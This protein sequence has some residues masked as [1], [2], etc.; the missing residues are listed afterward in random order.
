M[1]ETIQNKTQLSASQ[2]VLLALK[3]AKIRIESYERAKSEP[4]AI[5]GMGCR[6]PGGSDTPEKYW[7]FLRSGQSGI[8]EIPKDRWDMNALYD[9]DPDAPGKIYIRHGGFLDR[10][11]QFDPSFFRISPR[12]AE[13]MDPQQ[14]L[15]LEVSY[16]ALYHAGIEPKKLSGSQTGVFVGIGQNDYSR[17]Q[18]NFGDLTRINAYDGTGNLFC[19][20]SG[21]LSYTLGLNG[22]NLTLD[23]ACSSSLVAIHLACQSLRSREC[24][25]ALAGGVH[26]VFSPEITVF[27][28]R[29]HVLS[30]DGLCRTFD[31]SAN[32]FGRGEGCGMIV[33]KRLSDA[34]AQNDNIL[35]LIRGSAINHDGAS[36][37]LTV[38]NELAQEALIRQA[39]TNAKVESSQIGY[40]EAHGTG[41]SLGDPIELGALASVFKEHSM[42]IG[43]V[44]TNFGHLEAA[45]GIAGLMKV[46][47]ALQ[48]HEIPPHLHF[49]EP[50]PR[51]DWD[52]YPFNVPT[53]NIAWESS[54]MAG[55]SSFGMSGTNAHIILEESPIADSLQRV[56]RIS[57][58]FQRE[59]YWVQMP[60]RP[61][62]VM[63]EENSHPLLGKKLRLPFSQ[64]IRFES[65]LSPESP[66]FMDDHRIFGQVISPAASHV[67]TILSAVKLAF[68]KESCVLEE[69]FFSRALV[70]SE[71]SPRKVQ[72]ILTPQNSETFAFNLV[73]CGEH[74][75]DSSESSWISHVSGKLRLSDPSPAPHTYNNAN[76]SGFLHS[77][78]GSSFYANLHQAGYR[79][80]TA[81]Q[82]G[83]EFWQGETEALCRI[84]KPILPDSA[85]DY[86]LYPGLLDTCFQ[87][88]SSFWGVK[89]SELTG[90]SDLYVPFSISELKFYKRPDPNK[91]L[92]CKSLS[93]T[94]KQN[95]GHLCLFDET[96]NIFA[97]VSGFEFRKANRQ[98]LFQSDDSEQEPLITL[99]SC[100]YQRNWIPK[101]LTSEYPKEPKN[102]LIF[103]DNR[104]IGRELAAQ[105]RAL[106]HEVVSV[107]QNDSSDIRELLE[108][109]TWYGIVHL[110]HLNLNESNSYLPLFNALHL[111]QALA[112]SASKLKLWIVTQGVYPET[113]ANPF[114][115]FQAPVWGLARTL[116]LEHPDISCVCADLAISDQNNV[117]NLL[118]E[119]LTPD[120]ENEITWRN[121]VRHAARL[122]RFGIQTQKQIPISGDHSYLISGGFGALG[123]RA[124]QWLADQSARHLVLVSRRSPSD[125]ARKQISEME[126]LGVKVLVLQADIS[127]KTDADMV[128]QKIHTQMPELRGIIHAAGTIDDAVLL[129]QDE[130][131]LKNVMKPKIDGS[132][133]LHF[134]TQDMKLDFFVC[135]SS[136][137]SLLGSA[138]QGN[139]AAANAFM[140]ALARHRRAMGLPATSIQWGAWSESGMAAEL[141]EQHQR[142]LTEQ[143]MGVIAPDQGVAILGQLL[144]E[145][146]AEAA[147]MSVDWAKYLKNFPK[148]PLLSEFAF[149]EK[150]S[151]STVFA[152]R[153]ETMP[154]AERRASVSEFVRSQV[155]AVLKLK[156][157]EKIKLRERLFD[158]GMDSLMAVELRNRLSA[159]LEKPLPATLVFDY[160]T[161]EALSDYLCSEVLTI[162]SEQ[163]EIMQNSE[164]IADIDMDSL[165]NDIAQKSDSDLLKELRGLK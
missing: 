33:L 35:A 37:G 69:V 9:S 117:Q 115:C 136:V 57:Q 80:G 23:T 111:I 44:K 88:L 66:P 131:R 159:E 121:G 55:V 31:S 12:E 90:S 64:E 161:V 126:Q 124:A 96:G 58:S 2:R 149:K 113:S 112:R 73:S 84:E 128:F 78:P 3:E 138:G 150:Q 39:L 11:D 5:I 6:F 13:S 116:A 102:W 139:Y 94:E 16:E 50:T 104:G 61:Q 148:I 41:T 20:A 164:D 109:R 87:L 67:S 165:L 97:E 29:T 162:E 42:Y 132:W 34:L 129:R 24:D 7:E 120:G 68:G 63:I 14:R 146:I 27:L 25:M 106:G 107:F 145:E 85:D 99:K 147:V 4:I 133:N 100:L 48:H 76:P 75:D 83:Q 59:R 93:A 153:L 157:A 156:S 151:S 77:E 45:A 130:N 95:S 134:L 46:V 114:S 21:R 105:L 62:Q 127:D 142:R 52:R 70:L 154:K 40:I 51:F 26:L 65:L 125:H 72:L 140:D 155:A 137:A 89:A 19:F 15:L 152:R 74:D 1:T 22:P 98:A 101:P 82:W 103:S 30:P 53:K 163:A 135:Y 118:H 60:A 54:R 86:Q 119:I 17:F 144:C 8:R 32:G 18:L 91:R 141:N 71:S 92:W 47:L 43:S 122:T 28:C 10:T 38:P 36:S 108:Q 143:G 56:G 79:L 123:L 158:A 81:F 160:P 49:K 110:W